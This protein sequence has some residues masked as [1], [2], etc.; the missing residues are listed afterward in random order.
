MFGA[1]QE[2]TKEGKKERKKEGGWEVKRGVNADKRKRRRER[3]EV[4]GVDE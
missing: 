4:K 3:R 1:E 2:D